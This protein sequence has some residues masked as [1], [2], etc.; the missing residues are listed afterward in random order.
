[1]RDH[2]HGLP[3]EALGERFGPF[4]ARDTARSDRSRGLGV[5]LSICQAIV[6]AHGGTI[7]AENAPDGGARI[8]F[9]LP[10]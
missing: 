2:G 5:G 1:M 7:L 6:T 9:T 4:C 3:A 10:L 8:R